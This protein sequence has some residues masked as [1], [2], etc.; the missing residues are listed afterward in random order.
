MLQTDK[1]L[2]ILPARLDD[3]KVGPDFSV[4]EKL[5][6]YKALLHDTADYYIQR[7]RNVYVYVYLPDYETCDL[8]IQVFPLRVKVSI[9]ESYRNIY[10]E[11]VARAFEEDQKF[12][13]LLEIS[14]FVYPIPWVNNAYEVMTHKYDVIVTSIYCDNPNRLVG[15]KK[16][17][18]KFISGLKNECDEQNILKLVSEL[19]VLYVPLK[20]INYAMDLES[21]KHVFSQVIYHSKND[22]FKRTKQ[23]IINLLKK[24]K[25]SVP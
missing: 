23:V 6:I 1:A 19:D 7:S 15:L 8:L 16:L 14:S 12:V 21:L 17:H 5:E 20:R 4:E 11:S 9:V 25:V 3:L 24:R 18:E 2:I 13:V 22:E 10:L